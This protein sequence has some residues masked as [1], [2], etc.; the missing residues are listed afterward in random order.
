MATSTVKIFF[1]TVVHR[2]ARERRHWFPLELKGRTA[3]TWHTRTL[4]SRVVFAPP[5]S[6][7]P[8]RHLHL[9]ARMPVP[10]R[11]FNGPPDLCL[12]RPCPRGLT[13]T[14]TQQR[15][16][17]MATTTTT[18]TTRFKFVVL[19]SNAEYRQYNDFSTL[20]VWL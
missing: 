17:R 5:P 2:R 18:T 10:P 19:S 1:E 16:R 15:K 3:N 11:A 4:Y 7:S 9:R 12:V 6:A 13:A 14:T 20:R 8:R